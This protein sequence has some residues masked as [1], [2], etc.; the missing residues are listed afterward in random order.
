MQRLHSQQ[1]NFKSFQLQQLATMFTGQPQLNPPELT[2]KR[3]IQQSDGS[4][5][6]L[7]EQPLLDALDKKIAGL[8]S[9]TDEDANVL[10]GVFNRVTTPSN[11]NHR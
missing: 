10:S 3:W 2:F 11:D 1:P 6:T 7:S 5:K 8:A 4:I 9:N